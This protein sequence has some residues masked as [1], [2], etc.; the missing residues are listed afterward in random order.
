MGVSWNPLQLLHLQKYQDLP[1]RLQ[2]FYHELTVSTGLDDIEKAKDLV[3]AY[4]AEHNLQGAD[5]KSDTDKARFE[6]FRTQLYKACR[7]R[8]SE[9]EDSFNT[10]VIN[11]IIARELNKRATAP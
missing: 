11:F 7:S 5:F 4:T 8:L 2:P 1:K 10:R 9:S 6:S 3:H